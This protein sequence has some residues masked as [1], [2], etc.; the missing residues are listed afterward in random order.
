MAGDRC[1]SIISLHYSW[2]NIATINLNFIYTR[3]K[4][5]PCIPFTVKLKFKF[6]LF[7]SWNLNNDPAANVHIFQFLK[8]KCSALSSKV[9]IPL[10]SSNLCCQ[11]MSTAF[12]P[13]YSVVLTNMS[14][15]A[16][17]SQLAHWL[18]VSIKLWHCLELL[19]KSVHHMKLKT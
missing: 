13:L 16:T 12:S 8:K 3:D 5:T 14:E 7:V 11:P 9:I 2:I 6:S 17:A 4:N 19:W 15:W 10:Y 1:R 18:V